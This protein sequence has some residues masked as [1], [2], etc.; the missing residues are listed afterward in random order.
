MLITDGI[1]FRGIR[2]VI[3]RGFVTDIND[4]IAA[5]RDVPAPERDDVHFFPAVGAFLSRHYAHPFL[6]SC[7]TK[8][9]YH[10]SS[11]D[12]SLI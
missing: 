4:L 9:T 8:S 2:S 1:F 11:R 12:V 3:L 5:Y 6:A 7:R 10:E